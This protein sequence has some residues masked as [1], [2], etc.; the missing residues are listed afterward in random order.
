[1]LFRCLPIVTKR[2][3][4]CSSTI[5]FL[6]SLHLAD[7]LVV[8]Q[9][10]LH[11]ICTDKKSVVA[12]PSQNSPH[13][14]KIYTIQFFQLHDTNFPTTRYKK[15]HRPTHAPQTPDLRPPNARPTPPKHQTY[16]LQTPNLRLPNAQHTTATPNSSP[17][18]IPHTLPPPSLPAFLHSLPPSPQSSF[19]KIFT[20]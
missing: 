1:M 14:N 6:P 12:P 2:H 19:A 7:V 10:I 8:L 11:N 20:T 9:A 5:L 18:K 13:T 4:R 15:F 3:S 16:N 17:P